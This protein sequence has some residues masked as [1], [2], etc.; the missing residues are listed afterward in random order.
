MFD[1]SD[2]NIQSFDVTT[3][4]IIDE[5]SSTEFYV[6]QSINSKDLGKPNW[7]IRRIW[8]V[9]SVWHFG[10][11]NGDQDFKYVWDLRDTYDYS[12]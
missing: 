10:F 1:S 8:M 4:L 11:P 3:P 12:I 6:G 2:F 7:R 9:G 5:I